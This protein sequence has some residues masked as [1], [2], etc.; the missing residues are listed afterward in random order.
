MFIKVFDTPLAPEILQKD[1][2]NSDDGHFIH[3]QDPEED[4]FIRGAKYLKKNGKALG[5]IKWYQ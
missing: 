1:F 5:A 3:W 4:P 2:S